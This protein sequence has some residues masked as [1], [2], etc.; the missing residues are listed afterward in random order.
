[1]IEVNSACAPEDKTEFI[2]LTGVGISF[3]NRNRKKSE[4]KTE[5]A[6]QLQ[7]VVE[8]IF[9]KMYRWRFL[10]CLAA[11]FQWNYTGHAESDLTEY[12]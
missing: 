11:A 6:S 3:G 10:T 5:I 4:K 2:T 7:T 8:K 12:I 9:N 1:M